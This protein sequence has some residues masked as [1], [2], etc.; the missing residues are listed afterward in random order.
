MIQS[1]FSG[2]SGMLAN[3]TEMDVIGDNIA[4]AN[5]DG[6]KSATANF[7]SSFE[8]VTSAATANQ[9]VGLEVGLGVNVGSTVTNFNQGVFQTTNVPTDM[10]I[11]GNGWFT[12][13]TVGGTNL[14]TRDGDFVEDSNGY[15][16]TPDGAY[17]MGVTG[18]TAPTSPTTGSPPDKIQIPTTI[19]ATSS[20]VV[21]FAVDST[22]AVTATGQ[23][24][25]TETVGFITLQTFS[26]NNGLVDLGNNYYQY[27]AA[28]GTNQYFQASQ[29][30][31]GTI[32][33]GVLEA[34]NVDLSTE[35]ANMIIAQRGFEASARVI[36]V[37]DNM[38]QTVT[39]LKTQ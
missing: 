21:S 19:T 29:A 23:D 36:T 16:R 12:V 30:G 9:P 32:Q 3:Q 6:Y 13:Q 2:V 11:N 20:P 33:T 24:G 28:A 37:S 25:S 39:D 15:L 22:G 38:L 1:L 4:N 18:T 7:Q 31:A 26:N 5:T 27:A 17:L 8:Q 14:L 34:S 35:F 10:G